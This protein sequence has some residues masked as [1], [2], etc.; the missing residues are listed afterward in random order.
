MKVRKGME[1]LEARG[2]EKNCEIDWES[3]RVMDFGN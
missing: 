3:R 2:K 1:I